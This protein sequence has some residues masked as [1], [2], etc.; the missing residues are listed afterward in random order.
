MDQATKEIYEFLKSLFP[1]PKCELD[2]ETNFQLLIS[3]ILSAQCTDKR[4]NEVV[5]VLFK[6]FPT[7]K[8]LAYA[9]LNE[10]EE[11]VRPCGFFHVKAKNIISASKEIVEKH[12]GE[13]PENFNSLLLLS[14]VGQK[15]ANVITCVAFK[16]PAFAVD[17]HVFRVA[18]RLGL[19]SGK[20]PKTV[21]I[22]LKEIFPEENWSEAH[23]LFVLFGRYFCKARNPN[24][25]KCE[26]ANLCGFYKQKKL[27]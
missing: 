6:K 27:Q 14:G 5:K 23:H 17:T 9:N 7:P 15:T 12:G 10:V 13:V 20:N 22:D 26:L 11:I 16:K 25:G 19:S 2:F 4:V 8:D 24:C 1:N 21:E 3:V 18:K